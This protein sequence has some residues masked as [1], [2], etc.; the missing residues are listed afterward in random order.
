MKHLKK[1]DR[2][3]ILFILT[4]QERENTWIPDYMKLPGRELLKSKGLEFKN[5]YTHTSP[6]SPS[7]ASIFT[8]KHIHQHGVTEN[9]SSPKN[10]QLSFEELTIGKI[11]RREGY[12]TAYKGKW[13]LQYGPKPDMDKFGFGDWVGNDMSFWG[14]PNSGTEYDPIITENTIAWLKNHAKDVNP[15]FLC[16]G[17]VNPHDGMWFPVDQKWYMEENPGYT[18][19]TKRYL[20]KRKWGRKNN[21]PGFSDN[22]PEYINKLP[23]NFYDDLDTKPSVHKVWMKMMLKHSLPG[24]INPEDESLWLMQLNYYLH[25]HILND[26]CL[27]KIL[28]TLDQKDLWK[29][30]I[31]IF[32]SDH[33]DQCGSHKL[34]SKGPWNYQETMNVPLYIVSPEWNLPRVTHNLTSHIDLA[35]TIFNLAAPNKKFEY[36]FKGNSLIDLLEDPSEAIREY[37]YFAQEWPWYPGVEKVRYASSGFFDGRFKYARYYGVGGG[38]TNLGLEM[39]GKMKI[40]RDAPFDLVE[41]ELYDLQ[42]DP[43]ELNNLGHTKSSKV[44]LTERQYQ[45]LNQIEKEL[46]V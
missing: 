39:K 22:V 12:Y 46:G 28:I 34:R 5:H 30:T 17:L 9:S 36:S 31:I 21:L 26:L 41:H 42:E 43:F 6:C 45:R 38:V 24:T 7:R 4:D 11:L 14:L 18:N 3:N 23:I 2:Y 16:V 19:I 32:T 29:N 40:K 44:I 8:G 20:E 15:W 37:V 27:E 35:P 13:H 1:K 25:L 10:T 33:G